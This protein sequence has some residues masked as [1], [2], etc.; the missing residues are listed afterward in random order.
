MTPQELAHELFAHEC[1]AFTGE[2]PKPHS[3]RCQQA[4]ERLQR[5]FQLPNEEEIALVLINGLREQ[6]GLSPLSVKTL[7]NIKSWPVKPAT[8]AQARALLRFL[9]E[10]LKW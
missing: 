3:V 9:N 6:H 1:F 10:R 4:A 7:Q 8:M 2:G 5:V